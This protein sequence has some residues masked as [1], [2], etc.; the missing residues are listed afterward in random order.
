MAKDRTNETPDDAP[1]DEV[2]EEVM[3]ERGTM[4]T[5]GAGG[6]GEE[7]ATSANEQGG[8]G[9]GAAAER[10]AALEREVA[11]LKDQ[12]LRALADAEN[13]RRR[14]Q[15][16]REDAA[17]FGA[18][19]LARDLLSVADNLRRAIESV[20]EDARAGDAA[21]ESLVSGVE[22]VER[23]LLSAFGKHGIE[24]IVPE[25]ERFDPNLHQAMFEVE[26]SGQPAG[27]VVQVLQPGYIINGRLLRAAMVGVAKGEPAEQRVDTS[28]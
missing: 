6:E 9:G 26:D 1:R 12:H 2:P 16:D 14:A 8:W 11:E 15:R 17:K 18:T 24:K 21:L 27:T 7:Q 23:E 10:I 20:P 19:G 13:A 3:A 28:A 5:D 4:A 25:G 22:M